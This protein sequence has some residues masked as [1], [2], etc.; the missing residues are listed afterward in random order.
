MIEKIM[1]EQEHFSRMAEKWKIDPER[2]A[3]AER[4]AGLLSA[5]IH[6][7]KSMVCL[8]IGAGTGDLSVLLSEK[9][10]DI[11]LLDS[12][13]GM[14][15][16]I[17]EKI[18]ENRCGNLHPLPGDPFGQ[19]WEEARFDLVFAVMSFH[20]IRDT[21]RL[22]KII[23]RVLKPGGFFCLIDL[24]KED[25]SFHSHIP[26]FDGHNGF[27]REELKKQLT[28]A[29]LSVLSNRLVNEMKKPGPDGRE[30]SYPLFFMK[31]VK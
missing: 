8:E 26:G 28:G 17:R 27:D 20:H 11:T 3:R 1:N 31:A 16:V 9:V 10:G 5:E 23:A 18:R 12:N 7:D 13:A 6:L 22:L 25:G 24:E 2:L 21:E 30:R 14:I 19:N 15:N 4:T 29:G